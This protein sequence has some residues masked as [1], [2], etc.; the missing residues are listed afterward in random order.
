MSG[1]RKLHLAI[2]MGSESGRA[3][4]GW[5]EDGKL[6]TESFYR[7]RT[8]FMQ[9]RDRSVRDLYRIHEEIM[10]ALKLYAKQYGPKLDSISVDAFG[11]DFVILNRDGNLNHLPESCRS[12]SSGDEVRRYVEEHYG[13]RR[14]Y[15]R[16]G[17]QQLPMDVLH[18]L[19][20]MKLSN[21]PALDDP[22][23]M[24]WV[25]DT[26]HYLLGG[27]PCCERS[28]PTFARFY[29]VRE[30]KWDDEVLDAFGLPRGICSEVVEPAT[31]TGQIDPEILRIC[32]LE[33][34]VPIIS[35]CTHDTACALISVPD[36]NRDWVF[37][38]CGTWALMG[39]ETDQPVISDFSFENN[40]SN[41]TIPFGDN[42][43]KRNVTGTWIIQ[44][45]RE[46]WGDIPYDEIVNLAEQAEDTDFSIDINSVDF[47]APKDMLS[48]VTGAVE[49]DFGVKIDRNDVGTISRIVFESM[50]LK[51]RMYIENL[52]KA[53]DRKISKIYMLGGGSKNRL[54]NQ[55]TANACGYPVY[56]GVYEASS[57]GN[58]LLQMVGSGELADKK[59]MREVSA[60]TFPQTVFEPRNREA[61]DRK[62]AVYMER[63]AKQN[64][65]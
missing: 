17:N 6:R 32:G 58:L 8:Q 38:S 41:S 21:D 9:I 18:T 22:H 48:A 51:Y 4:V 12:H 34:P 20:R 23:G 11:G 7:F 59:Q 29:N 26:M 53:A 42:M 10:E 28:M 43:F 5:L 19:I 60:A 55:Y 49:R 13:A 2:D 25:A 3:I 14:L 45:C 52:L 39:I 27:R 44:Q 50:V 24:L 63:S 56:A 54:L 36:N 33:G 30:D 61:W 64:Q 47:F 62:F 65:W 57:T 46:K 16:N 15:M 37:I 35:A 31:V 1:M 40:F